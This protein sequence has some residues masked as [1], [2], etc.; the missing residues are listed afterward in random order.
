MRKQ[1][2]KS[3]RD[4]PEITKLMGKE[5]VLE[6]KC[7]LTLQPRQSH[8]CRGL[9]GLCFREETGAATPGPMAGG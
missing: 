9:S 1:R 7:T 4:Q 8:R 2:H 3:V 6:F 5:L